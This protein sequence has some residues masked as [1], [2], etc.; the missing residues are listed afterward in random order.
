M[1]SLQ[2]AKVK[3]SNYPSASSVFRQ[4]ARSRCSLRAQFNALAPSWDLEHGP[5]SPR[6]AEFTARVT[7]LQD[8]CRKLGRPRV[9]DLGCGTGQVLAHLSPLIDHGV[10][11]D[12]SRAMLARAR[13]AAPSSCLRFCAAD[14]IEFCSRCDERFDLVLLIGALDH[15]L[16]PEAALAGV[17][18]VI[19]PAGRLIV[20]SPH[21]WNPIFLLKR[22]TRSYRDIPPTKHISPSRLLALGKRHCFRFLHVDA[23]PY[24]AWPAATRI[25]NAIRSPGKNPLIEGAFAIEFRDS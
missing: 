9:L 2:H 14:A 24:A 1:S 23:L 5:A 15:L 19:R 4:R 22:L 10:G 8:R 3:T 16:D 7:Y 21:P 18:R 13:R 6:A 17:K 11:V 25:L 12:I 20:I